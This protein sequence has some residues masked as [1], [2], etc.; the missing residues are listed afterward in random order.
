MLNSNQQTTGENGPR[1]ADV[2]SSDS[3]VVVSA[4]TEDEVHEK[5][6][7]DK[8]DETVAD[9]S[10][11]A[12]KGEVTTLEVTTSATTGDTSVAGNA[13]EKEEEKS[14]TQGGDKDGKMVVVSSAQQQRE[15]R[16]RVNRE[17]MERE[18]KD[19][20]RRPPSPHR[21]RQQVLTFQHIRVFAVL[22]KRSVVE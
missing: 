12:K 3:K 11:L 7:A 19:R 6:C 10:P 9:L 13:K 2:K 15:N 5:K 4:G 18:R 1:K 16:E 22:K 14:P 8:A 21:P 17:R 20:P